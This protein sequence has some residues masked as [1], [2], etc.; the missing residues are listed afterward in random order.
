MP[1]VEEIA[2]AVAEALESAHES[3]QDK[4]HRAK[5]RSAQDIADQLQVADK[6]E[7]GTQYFVRVR[8]LKRPM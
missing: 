8:P 3:V 5:F 4:T 1:T 2:T 7:N 6:L